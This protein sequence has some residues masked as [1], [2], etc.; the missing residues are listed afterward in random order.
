MDDIIAEPAPASA[1]IVTPTGGYGAF[2]DTLAEDAEPPA[3]ALTTPMLKCRAIRAAQSTP[4]PRRRAPLA[5][6]GRAADLRVHPGACEP[7]EWRL[8]S[9]RATRQQWR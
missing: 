7:P 2:A 1:A 9:E 5:L 3:V 8:T 6:G 4:A